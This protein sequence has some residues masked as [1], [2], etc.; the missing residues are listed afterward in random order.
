MTLYDR[1]LRTR[2][3][4]AFT[5]HRAS[6][7]LMH[8]NGVKLPAPGLRHVITP[9]PA[10]PLGRT[11]EDRQVEPRIL[12]EIKPDWRLGSD[13]LNAARA[14][15]GWGQAILARM[16]EQGTI[17]CR[18]HAVKGVQYRLASAGPGEPMISYADR[19]LAYV[20]AN[21]GKQALE[22][23]NALGGQ[24]ETAMAALRRL[25]A[26][27]LVTFVQTSKRRNATCYWTA[28]CSA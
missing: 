25:E 22:V 18:P 27:G 15:G 14:N 11:K 12:S 13:I 8:P 17:V 23:A 2:D 28:T 6:Q 24:R 10:T 1:T 4:D 26:R 5:F 9:K 20:K 21:P 16:L 7:T 3:G 19:V